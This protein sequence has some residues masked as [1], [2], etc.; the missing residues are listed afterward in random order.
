MSKLTLTIDGQQ[1]V[2]DS[3]MTV[4]EAAASAGIYI[5]SL[6]AHPDLPPSGECGL[7]LVEIEGQPELAISCT[8]KVTESIVVHTDTNV[9]LTKQREVMEKILSEHP[10]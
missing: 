8:T 7:C 5:P 4:F 1:I 6:C 3:G 9:I 2:V 10:N